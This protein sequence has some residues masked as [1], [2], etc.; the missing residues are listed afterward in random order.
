VRL[1]VGALAAL[2]VASCVA[3]LVGMALVLFDVAGTSEL[4]PALTLH[5]PLELGILLL[6][7]RLSDKY[8]HLEMQFCHTWMS[9]YEMQS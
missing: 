9:M 7:N 3:R 6:P 1:C 4:D 5:R 8:F 2:Y